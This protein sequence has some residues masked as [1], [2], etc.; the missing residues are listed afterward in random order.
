MKRQST[1]NLSRTSSHG[2][3][4]LL[5]FSLPTWPILLFSHLF[6]LSYLV[7]QHTTNPRLYTN[8]DPHTNKIINT[9]FEAS[10]TP[11]NQTLTYPIR[12][13]NHSTQIYMANHYNNKANL[14]IA[15]PSS[16]ESSLEKWGHNQI[17]SLELKA[18]QCPHMSHLAILSIPTGNQ[19][20]PLPTTY[21]EDHLENW[22][23][24]IHS[25]RR[26]HY[27]ISWVI[28]TSKCAPRGI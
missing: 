26:H 6:Y 13:P 14:T 10:L 7:N 28:R 24:T 12:N 15:F 20:Y 25:H 3:S 23:R 19:P 11:T 9:S 17:T 8:T 1:T 27:C 22:I 4:Q 5:L 18:R 21:I 2:R 16:L